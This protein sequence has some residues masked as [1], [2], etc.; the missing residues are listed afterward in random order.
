MTCPQCELLL[1]EEERGPEVEAH[2]RECASCR[3]LS[4]DLA[5][6][7]AVLES[8]KSDELPRISVKTPPRVLAGRMLGYGVAAAAAAAGLVIALVVPR[9][10][11]PTSSPSEN[12]VV[13]S[14]PPPAKSQTKIKMLTPDPNVVIYWLADN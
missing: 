9:T 14:N 12:Q 1:A 11:A 13:V 4:L 7:S 8:L 10:P 6:N 5:A 3:G 2:L